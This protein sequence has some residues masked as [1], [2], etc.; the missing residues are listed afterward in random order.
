[1]GALGASYALGLMKC[2]CPCV[3]LYVSDPNSLRQE[4]FLVFVFRVKTGYCPG[5]LTQWMAGLKEK[6]FRE[7]GLI[8]D[9]WATACQRHEIGR[10]SSQFRQPYPPA[11]RCNRQSR[12]C[13]RGHNVEIK[14][15]TSGSRQMQFSLRMFLV[16][17]SQ[18]QTL[19]YSRTSASAILHVSCQ[20]QWELKY[21]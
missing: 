17:E 18:S 4:S 16:T 9:T 2:V 7:S 12:S 21:L 3:C 1:M 10:R 20:R 5:L 19:R 14:T 8:C 11:C 15:I 13:E 6:L